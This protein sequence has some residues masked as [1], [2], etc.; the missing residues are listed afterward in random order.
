MSKEQG[1]V[2]DLGFPDLISGLKATPGCIGV[3]TARTG[4][5]KEVIFA[6]FEDKKAVLNWY[7]SEA[8]QRVMKAF[9]QNDAPGKPLH[10]VPDDAG[11][12]MVIASVTFSDRPLFK[13]TPLPISQIAIEAYQPITKGIALG[14]RFAPEGVKVKR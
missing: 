12:I 14:G 5:G 11:P 10:G 13:E 1:S 4:S 2:Q 7:H 3:E 9:F 6:W 8:H